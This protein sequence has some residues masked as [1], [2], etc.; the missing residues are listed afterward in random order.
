MRTAA[1]DKDEV[2]RELRRLI[3][4]APKIAPSITRCDGRNYGA[5]TDDGFD[6]QKAQRWEVEATSTLQYLACTRIQAFALLNG[7]YYEKRAQAPQNHSR[8][9]FIHQAVQCLTTAIELLDSAVVEVVLPQ[10]TVARADLDAPQKVTIPWLLKHVPVTLW[11]TAIG[12][13]AASFLLGI[14]AA[15]SRVVQSIL[16]LFGR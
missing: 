15:E 3:D 14:R 12:L 8:S 1:V 11:L 4:E 9:I 6:P 10:E 13:L 5:V 2:R 16:G 7:Q